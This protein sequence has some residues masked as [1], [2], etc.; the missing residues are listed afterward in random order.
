MGAATVSKTKAA[1]AEVRIEERTKH[2]RDGLLDAAKGLVFLPTQP[3]PVAPL[4]QLQQGMLEQ[5]HGPWLAPDIGQDG[6]T[7]VCLKVQAYCRGLLLH[8]PAHLRGV[9]RS[10]KLL[11]GLHYLF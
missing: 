6:V 9:Q 2:L 3:A 8:R 11:V 7:Q 10:Y 4:P 1:F 5:R